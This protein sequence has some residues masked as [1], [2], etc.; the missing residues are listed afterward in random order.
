MCGKGVSESARLAGELFRC[1]PFCLRHL[2]QHLALTTPK[3]PR[4]GSNEYEAL[5]HRR[6]R[7]R[8]VHQHLTAFERELLNDI[9]GRFARIKSLHPDVNLG[10]PPEHIREQVRALIVEFQDLTSRVDA[11]E[12]E[13]NQAI[14]EIEP[15]LASP[16]SSL[17]PEFVGPWSE[18]TRGGDLEESKDVKR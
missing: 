2:Q 3:T 11:R 10:R 1:G 17:H 15:R 13:R 4:R 5:T 7:A 8:F 14:E 12:V 18:P 9:I 16:R 6:E